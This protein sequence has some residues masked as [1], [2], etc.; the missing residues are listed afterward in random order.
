MLARLENFDV[1]E[2]SRFDVG[3]MLSGRPSARQASSAAI[4]WV[5]RTI[6]GEGMQLKVDR[7]E[8]TPHSGGDSLKEAFH[9]FAS[10]AEMRKGTRS[11]G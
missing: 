2:L 11:R 3:A 10:I 7:A 6:P 5:L 1:V 4:V 9:R 8:I